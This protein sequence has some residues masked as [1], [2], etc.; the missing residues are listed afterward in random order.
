[1]GIECVRSSSPINLLLHLQTTRSLPSNRSLDDSRL[2]C[3]SYNNKPSIASNFSAGCYL[4]SSNI[5]DTMLAC[6]RA[7]SFPLVHSSALPSLLKV[8]FFK[9]IFW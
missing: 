2:S 4:T 1:M 9:N 5:N 3:F 6:R 8:C 7:S